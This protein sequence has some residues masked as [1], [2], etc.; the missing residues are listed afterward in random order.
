MKEEKKNRVFDISHI[1]LSLFIDCLLL[2]YI[3]TTSKVI[4]GGALTCDSTHSWRLLSVAPLGYQVID[5]MTQYP[6]QSHY[7]NTV[8]NRRCP[9]LAVLYT[10]LCSEKYKGY[11]AIGHLQLVIGLTW[12]GFK[13]WTFHM[14]S[15]HSATT[16]GTMN[17]IAPL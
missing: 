10:R 15:L 7:P 17:I 5:T 16:S 1:T 13:L 6:T 14:G 2:F 4:S 9:I 11:M 3:L 12:L 8:V